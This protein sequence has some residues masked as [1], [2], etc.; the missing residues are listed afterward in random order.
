MEQLPLSSTCMSSDKNP[1]SASTILLDWLFLPPNTQR[2]RREDLKFFGSKNFL[3]TTSPFLFLL[4]T[5]AHLK[6]AHQQW[7]EQKKTHHDWHVCFHEAEAKKPMYRPVSSVDC[8]KIN[9][10]V[11]KL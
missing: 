9:Q 7:K 8:T 3:P 11:L 4:E 10:F 1:A 6:E 5:Q 2:L